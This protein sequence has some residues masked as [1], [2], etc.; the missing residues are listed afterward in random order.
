MTQILAPTLLAVFLIVGAPLLTRVFGLSG[1]DE[2][3]VRNFCRVLGS[4]GLVGA[5]IWW[6]ETRR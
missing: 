2:R 6:L 4:L 3:L 1:K 5:L